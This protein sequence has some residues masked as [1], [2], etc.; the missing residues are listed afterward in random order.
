MTAL[1]LSSWETGVDKKKCFYIIW[2]LSESASMTGLQSREYFV[3][4]GFWSL[5]V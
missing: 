5:W 4:R 3:A 2:L 1:Y